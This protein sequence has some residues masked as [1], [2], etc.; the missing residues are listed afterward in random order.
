MSHSPSRDFHARGEGGSL[1]LVVSL[2]LSLF[3]VSLLLCALSFCF[4]VPCIIF[5]LR[6]FFWHGEQRP[7][8]NWPIVPRQGQGPHSG[9]WVPCPCVPLKPWA[10]RPSGCAAFFA[11]KLTWNKNMSRT[12]VGFQNVISV[13]SRGVPERPEGCWV[14]RGS[15]H[16]ERAHCSAQLLRLASDTTD[17]PAVRSLHRPGGQCGRCVAERSQGSPPP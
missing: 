13:T 7:R 3:A 8:V 10:S 4:S 14:R 15:Q 1:C 12:S 11:K 9:T 5:M 2:A 17:W 6:S 16:W